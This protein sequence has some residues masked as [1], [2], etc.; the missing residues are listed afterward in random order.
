[1]MADDL[2][3]TRFEWDKIKAG[4]NAGAGSYGQRVD[5]DTGKVYETFRYNN[6]AAAN[7]FKGGLSPAGQAVPP[8]L[9]GGGAVPPAGLGV[10]PPVIGGG[11]GGGN[12]VSAPKPEAREEVKDGV[13]YKYFVNPYNNQEVPGSRTV[14]EERPALSGEAAGR[15][16]MVQSSLESFNQLKDLLTPGGELRSDWKKVV[17]IGNLPGPLTALSPDA[18]KYDTYV[19]NALTAKLRLETGANMP[20]TELADLQARFRPSAFDPPDLV[21]NKL[22]SIESFLHGSIEMLDPNKRYSKETLIVKDEKG[23]QYAW[24][25]GEKP[26][27]KIDKTTA[28]KYLRMANG[29]ADEARR[30]ARAD[31]WEF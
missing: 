25:P 6:P 3:R 5:P 21:K 11:G 13:K 14:I 18:R 17:G 20:V 26:S 9:G 24:S 10:R 27:G 30:L 15:A 7:Y 31:G 29:N 12:L 19:R 22:N 8:V 4:L 23:N 1:L 28:A 16:G 2:D